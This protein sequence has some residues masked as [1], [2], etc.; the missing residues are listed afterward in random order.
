VIIWPSFLLKNQA[1]SPCRNLVI[2]FFSVTSARL[3]NLQDIPVSWKGLVMT[4]YYIIFSLPTWK[5]NSSSNN[6]PYI[7]L[8]KHIYFLSF[9]PCVMDT[10][11]STPHLM[12]V[13]EV[14]QEKI[15]N[16]DMISCS[17]PPSFVLNQFGYVYHGRVLVY[18]LSPWR[19]W[20]VCSVINTKDASKTM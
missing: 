20:R 11:D 9:A 17:L 18:S 19:I 16:M 7:S 13:R 10:Y 8:G 6:I 5:W 14:Q 3:L 12:W 15:Y 1:L 2:L 4:I